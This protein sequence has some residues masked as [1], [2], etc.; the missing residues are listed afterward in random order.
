MDDSTC[1]CREMRELCG[2]E[3]AITFTCAEHGAV[4]I[5]KRRIIVVAEPERRTTFHAPGQTWPAVE[6]P[7]PP[8]PKG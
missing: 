3:M 1:C 5:D 4:V 8:L 2:A 7:L 6:F